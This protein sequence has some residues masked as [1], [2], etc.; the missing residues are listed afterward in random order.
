MQLKIRRIRNAVAALGVGTALVLALPAA[1]ANA[2]LDPPI[3]PFP[4]CPNLGYQV[5]TQAAQ[6]SV[7][8][9][10]DLNTSTFVPIKQLPT[11]VNAIGYSTTQNVFWGVDVKSSMAEK[12]VRI[13]SKGNLDYDLAPTVSAGGP[14]YAPLT[15]VT[16]AVNEDRLY[17]HTKVPA[18]HLLVID[19]DPDSPTLGVVLDDVTLSRTTPGEDYLNIG[20]WDFNPVDGKLYALEWQGTTR[21]T[22]VSVDP[23]TGVVADVFD[24]T[25]KIPDGQNFGA[26]Y[27]E[28]GDNILYVSDNDVNR[29]GAHS[30]TF[31]VDISTGQVIAYTPGAPLTI[32]DGAGCLLPTDF[33]DAPQSYKTLNTDQGPGHVLTSALHKGQQLTIGQGVDPDLDGIPSP[34]ADGDDRNRPVNDE[35]GLA[36]DIVINPASTS[37]TIP[38]VNTTGA[39]ATLAGWIDFNVNGKFDAGERAV[40]TVPVGSTTVTL[41]WAP[42]STGLA[43]GLHT[44]VSRL[45]SGGSTLATVPVTPSYIRLRL[46]PGTVADPQATGAEFVAGGEIED[47]RILVDAPAL[48]VTGRSLT[49]LVGLGVFLVGAGMLALVL[50]QRRRRT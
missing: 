45:T 25:A 22:L 48:P 6:N 50:T 8:G 15:T 29:A 7:L 36:E 27:V 40:A 46:Y 4:S 31:S 3:A 39:P 32:N 35:D 21:R 12:L 11:L 42:A 10:F 41:T 38:C 14:A 5:Q 19:I 37:L 18:N 26:D 13:D 33:G 17:L 16:G 23:A 20:D 44:L 43:S 49:P 24:L 2:A 9:Y 34:L 28:K 47:H 30:Q 1:P